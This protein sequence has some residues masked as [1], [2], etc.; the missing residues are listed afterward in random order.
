[1]QG[2]YYHPLLQDTCPLCGQRIRS[3]GRGIDR[4]YY[5]WKIPQKEEDCPECDCIHTYQMPKNL[6]YRPPVEN[7][8]KEA[9]NNLDTFTAAQREHVE[10]LKR[11][12]D[13]Y[14]NAVVVGDT[15]YYTVSE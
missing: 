5:W 8:M 6:S 7:R 15:K 3:K 9:I 13:A 4:E 14:D 1:M 11:H 10:W 12:F 2:R